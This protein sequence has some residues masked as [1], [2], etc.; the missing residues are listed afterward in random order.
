LP[1]LK[2]ES[3]FYFVIFVSDGTV[4]CRKP[5]SDGAIFCRKFVS[6]GAIFCREN[7]GKAI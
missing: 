6:D 4:F 7:G 1:P 2:G 3:D 5:V